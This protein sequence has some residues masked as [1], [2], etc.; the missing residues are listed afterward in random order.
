MSGAP[1]LGRRPLLLAGLGLSLP[2]NMEAATPMA[3]SESLIPE[4]I[5]AMRRAD[6]NQPIAMLNLLKFRKQAVYPPG[7]REPP[8]TGEE[9]YMAYG[10]ASQRIIAGLGGRLLFTAVFERPLIGD[11]AEDWDRIAIVYYPTRAAFL[12]MIEMPEYRAL[13]P[14]RT[15]GLER[16]RLWQFD[17]SP[18]RA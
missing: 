17:G 5:A 3:E 16:S 10:A 9:A 7:S 13:T 2:F 12:R 11:P 8:R 1:A 18:F 6:P 14:M 15:A 4:Q